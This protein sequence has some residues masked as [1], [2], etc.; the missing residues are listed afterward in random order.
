MSIQLSA[1][2]Y[3]PAEETLSGQHSVVDQKKK[4]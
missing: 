2:S 1:I 3:Q 4:A